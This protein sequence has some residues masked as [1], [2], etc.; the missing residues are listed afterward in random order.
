MLD[1]GDI[2]EQWVEAG[3][4][5]PQVLLVIC[6]ELHHAALRHDEVAAHPTT[7]ALDTYL[8][9]SEKSLEQYLS[10]ASLGFE[11]KK[12]FDEHVRGKLA[13]LYCLVRQHI[14]VQRSLKAE[15]PR[16]NV[17]LHGVADLL[18]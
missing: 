1:G 13:Y 18:V 16:G 11:A 5:Q 12:N 8:V 2:D 17:V 3:R 6:R 14:F 7:L 15:T 9:L 10:L 4:L